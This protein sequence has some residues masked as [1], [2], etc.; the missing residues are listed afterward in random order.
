[1]TKVYQFTEEEMDLLREY[2]RYK[3]LVDRILDI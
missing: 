1:M 3:F 2:F